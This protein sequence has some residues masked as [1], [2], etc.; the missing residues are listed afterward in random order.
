ME[1]IIQPLVDLY[2]PNLSPDEYFVDIGFY[3]DHVL[4]A[5]YFD[6]ALE[7]LDNL[8]SKP[9]DLYTPT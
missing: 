2:L 3:L 8:L 9:D 7:I 1:D 5:A 4:R 6:M